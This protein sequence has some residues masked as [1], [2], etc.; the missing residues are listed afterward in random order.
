MFNK[1]VYEQKVVL[2]TML[3]GKSIPFNLAANTN[4]TTSLKKSKCHKMFPLN[5]FPL[6]IGV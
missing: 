3:E 6:K 4:H 2:P 5:V 1:K